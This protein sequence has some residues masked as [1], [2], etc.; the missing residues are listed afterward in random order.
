MGNH[1]V[2]RRFVPLAFALLVGCG[3]VV[4]KAPATVSLAQPRPTGALE[5]AP[6][7]LAQS[8]VVE[9]LPVVWHAKNEEDTIRRVARAKGRPV[10]VRFFAE[11]C[12][13]CRELDKTMAA[14]EVV[15]ELERFETVLV[16]ATDDEDPDTARLSAKYHVV[17]LPTIVVLDGTGREATRVLEYVDPS[18][19]VAKLRPV[20]AR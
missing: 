8:P 2:A 1:L 17:G 19:F 9:R 20:H 10:V 16:D 3:G 11:W 5:V 12:M 7:G 6:G 18:A 15:S 14:P 4:A 13:A